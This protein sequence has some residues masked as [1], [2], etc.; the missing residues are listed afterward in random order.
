[1]TRKH[2]K[3]VLI[4]LL[5][6]LS[7]IVF[8]FIFHGWVFA[9]CN[10]AYIRANV[11]QITPRVDGHLKVVHV[12][13]NQFVKKGDLLVELDPTPYQLH[14][15]VDAAALKQEQAQLE[16]AKTKLAMAKK[17]LEAF[18]NERELAEKKAARFKKLSADGAESR[19]NYEDVL[20]NLDNVKNKLT[21]GQ[22]ACR[23]WEDTVGV[24][25]TN[26]E[27]SKAK[28]ALSQYLLAQTKITAPANGH[29]VNIN[30]RPGDFAA[31]GQPMF[32]ILEDDVW[33]VKANYKEYMI[34]DI[35][36]GQTVWIQTDLY[37]LRLF[38]G[39][40][41]NVSRAISRTDAHDKIIP[42]VQPTTDWIRLERRFQVR[43]QFKNIPK[44]I[45]FCMGADARTLIKL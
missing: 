12:I 43:I 5:T 25:I 24:Q 15:D 6:I 42:Y 2:R 45:R 3:I 16:I 34:S 27:S 26:I 7:V 38:R 33:W 32:G 37:P 23:Y 20:S 14:V 40:V 41:I 22:E 4:F 35:K 10:D 39:E 29:V 11:V 44:D 36:P 19:Q 13:N 1:M 8:Y 28:L 9:Y 21:Q 17:K 30:A 18:Q 31:Q